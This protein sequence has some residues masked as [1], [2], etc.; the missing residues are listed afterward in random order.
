MRLRAATTFELCLNSRTA[1]RLH[2]FACL[3]PRSR[4]SAA[5]DDGIHH[6]A[7]SCAGRS[8]VWAANVRPIRKELALHGRVLAHTCMTN[9]KPTRL[10]CPVSLSTQLAYK[11][12]DSAWGRGGLI[13]DTPVVP[14][15]LNSVSLR[16]AARSWG[17]RSMSQTTHV[18][19]SSQDTPLRTVGSAAV[20]LKS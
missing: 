6:L 8:Q 18:K 2:V 20:S 7:D 15:V 17:T 16:T 14:R 9:E 3:M 19:L 13:D 12:S 10:V 5:R 11:D 1:A 4:S